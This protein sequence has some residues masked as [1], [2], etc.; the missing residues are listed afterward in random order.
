MPK[1]TIVKGSVCIE[2]FQEGEGVEAVMSLEMYKLWR[3]NIFHTLCVKGDPG[4]RI[5]DHG[6]GDPSHRGKN[7]Q[8]RI[9]DCPGSRLVRGFKIFFVPLPSPRW[10]GEDAWAAHFHTVVAHPNM[11]GR[12]V[13]ECVT[14]PLR[15]Q[16]MNLPFVFVPSSA[17]HPELSDDDI[18]EDVWLT[19]TVFGG[20]PNFVEVLMCDFENVGRRSAIYNSNPFD[21]RAVRKQRT[22]FY[23][24]FLEWHGL[25]KFAAPMDDPHQVAELMGFLSMNDSQTTEDIANMTNDDL[26]VVAENA[27]EHAIIDPIATLQLQKRC[28]VFAEGALFTPTELQKFYFDHYT[29]QMHRIEDVMTHRWHISLSSKNL[30][31]R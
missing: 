29:N 23:P 14:K 25:Q 15:S 12:E 4:A 19:G 13:Y 28:S 30:S 9:K 1:P 22:V 6:T 31:T 26:E 2:K 21:I 16:D 20:N 10:G 5:L 27:R 11:S 18:F 24:H 8:A 3:K 17:A 7:A